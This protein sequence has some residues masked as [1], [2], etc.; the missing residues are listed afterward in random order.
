MFDRII[1]IAKKYN[2]KVSGGV[3]FGLYKGQLVSVRLGGYTVDIINVHL[4]DNQKLIEFLLN[5][6]NQKILMKK[7]KAIH[8]HIDFWEDGICFDATIKRKK[9]KEALDEI[10]GFFAKFQSFEGHNI[11]NIVLLGNIPVIKSDDIFEKTRKRLAQKID[12]KKEFLISFLVIIIGSCIGGFISGLMIIKTTSFAYFFFARSLL[13]TLVSSFYMGFP[14]HVDKTSKLLIGGIAT[15]GLILWETI[16]YATVMKYT[17]ASKLSDNNFIEMLQEYILNFPAIPFELGSIL[18]FVVFILRR[19][20]DVIL[21]VTDGEVINKKIID[22]LNM[23]SREY[24]YRLFC[25]GIFSLILI[26]LVIFKKM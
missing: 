10:S 3:F 9:L 13:I 19:T 25:F 20:D 2:F 18:I 8:I 22:R 4:G 16:Q 17:G 1:N 11:H 14:E 23:V 5:K 12:H 24:R 26:G 7:L 15:L 21:T 6:E